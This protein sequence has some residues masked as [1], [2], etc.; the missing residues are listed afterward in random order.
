MMYV[1]YGEKIKSKRRNYNNGL[2]NLNAD[3]KV[4]FV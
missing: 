4:Y 3:I 1:M 2:A